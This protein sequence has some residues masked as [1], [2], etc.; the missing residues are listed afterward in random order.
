M[1][2]AAT[3]RISNATQTVRRTNS[4]RY[5]VSTCR[6]SVISHAGPAKLPRWPEVYTYLAGKGV[7]SISPQEA[8]ALV[9]GG[10][11]VLVDVRP[12]ETHEKAHPA[13]SISAPLYQPIDWSS[14]DAAKVFKA[15]AY[16]FNGVQPIE[17]NPAFKG[18]VTA[19]TGG[20]KGVIALCEAGGSLKPTPNF[21]AGK[22]SRS[23]QALYRVLSDDITDKVYHLDGGAFGWYKAGLPFVG[24][25]DA[26]NVGRTPNAAPEPSGELYEAA[27]GKVK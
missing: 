26:S 19:G 1:A 10:E 13:G 5:G 20:T 24:E 15:I 25:Y 16:S 21:P 4:V 22:A 18:Q 6:R 12:K 23:L 3:P 2:L 7:K 27:K 8:K 17:Q 9:D 14:V 11:W